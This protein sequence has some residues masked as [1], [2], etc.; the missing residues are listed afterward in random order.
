MAYVRFAVTHPAEFRIMFRPELSRA[1]PV[2]ALEYGPVFGLLMA[3]VDEVRGG[4]GAEPD[5]L[6]T[7]ISAWSL[8]HGLAALLVDGPLQPLAQNPDQIEPLAR[9]VTARLLM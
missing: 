3:V 1:P 7:A 2:D 6:T 5:R 9:A 8:V 4:T